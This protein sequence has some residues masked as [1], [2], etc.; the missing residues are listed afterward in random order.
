M[1][2]AW[3]WRRW[4]GAVK[5][6]M[7][8]LSLRAWLHTKNQVSAWTPSHFFRAWKW[9]IW[10]NHGK[11]ENAGK[12]ALTVY[13]K[14][15][16]WTTKQIYEHLVMILVGDALSH[17]TIKNSAPDPQL[18]GTTFEDMERPEY[19]VSWKI[20]DMGTLAHDVIIGD[21]W[22]ATRYMTRL[23]PSSKK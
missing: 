14:E 11:M 20:R 7:Q 23:R 19:R 16:D 2:V 4:A 21:R 5:L 18:R 1:F 8:Q 22:T 13:P 3:P 9:A 15:K 6:C 17:S 10:Q 12:R